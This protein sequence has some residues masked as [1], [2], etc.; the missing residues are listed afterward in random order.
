MDSKN[1]RE[2]IDA[3]YRKLYSEYMGHDSRTTE[4]KYFTQEEQLDR[5]SRSL[6]F[7]I[8]QRRH[9]RVSLDLDYDPTELMM[10]SLSTREVRE[11]ISNKFDPDGQS[12]IWE[13]IK[14]L[15]AE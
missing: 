15:L 6:A 3:K 7:W 5:Y 2:I 14:I 8:I 11:T 4:S 1:N 12:K 9:I 10:I 13:K